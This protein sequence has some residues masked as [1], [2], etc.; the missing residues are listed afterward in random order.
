MFSQASVILSGGGGYPSMHLGG[1][2]YPSKHL[3][4]RCVY[5][6]MHLGG[7]VWM[8]GVAKEGVVW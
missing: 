3:G 4:R 5:P 1:G 6:S 2:V 7:E 8:G